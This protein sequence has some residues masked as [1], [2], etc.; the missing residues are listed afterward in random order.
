MIHFEHR[1]PNTA[2]VKSLKQ[3]CLTQGDTASNPSSFS[4]QVVDTFHQQIIDNEQ[5]NILNT[6]SDKSDDSSEI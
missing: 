3:Y 2:E 5:K 4:D 1:L 6:K